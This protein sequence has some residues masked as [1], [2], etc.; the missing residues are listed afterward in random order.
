MKKLGLA[1]GTTRK[2]IQHPVITQRLFVYFVRF[3]I[4]VCPDSPTL[5]NPYMT[6][7][8][9]DRQTIIS[10]L[11][12]IENITYWDIT[13]IGNEIKIDIKKQS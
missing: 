4:T 10:R 6:F 3:V 12:K 13:Q 9:S 7:A 1:E 5:D 8:F 2:T 11:K